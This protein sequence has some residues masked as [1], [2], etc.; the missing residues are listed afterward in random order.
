M[1]LGY[2]AK[3]RREP[4][5]RG[6]A[7]AEA[8]KC[9]GKINEIDS[10]NLNKVFDLGEFAFLD[11]FDL[12]DVFDR[13]ELAVDRAVVDDGLRFNRAD[14]EQ[15]VQLLG[16][17]RIDVEL[18]A[19]RQLGLGRRRQ[20]IRQTHF[21]RRRPDAGE[22]RRRRDQSSALRRGC[23]QR[24]GIRARQKGRGES[25]GLHSGGEKYQP[26]MNTD[27]HG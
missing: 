20:K 24:R 17:G 13:L 9:R 25:A 6:E 1:K 22:R 23:L 26:R 4:Q 15:G 27:A 7:D 2:Y 8:E 18:L 5:P 3:K 19:E 21:P 11:A 14:P 16:R 10:L 12:H